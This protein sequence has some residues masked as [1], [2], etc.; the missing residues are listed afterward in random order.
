MKT[1]T[2]TWQRRVLADEGCAEGP[3][4]P[5]RQAAA[6]GGAG[7]GWL[8]PA[9]QAPQQQQWLGPREEVD[10][11]EPHVMAVFEVGTD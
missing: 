4:Q 6:A 5:T 9:T 11:M 3:S 10:Q 8:P 7:T 1:L 2:I